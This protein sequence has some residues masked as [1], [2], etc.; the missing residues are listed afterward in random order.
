MGDNHPIVI[1]HYVWIEAN[2]AMKHCIKIGN[3]S[4]I[5]STSVIIKDAPCYSIVGLVPG[6]VIR[7]RF[8]DS[9]II[10]L[11]SLC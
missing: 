7:K 5:F 3:G 2:V 1:D 9:Q 10:Q 6:K 8:G 11:G 4:I